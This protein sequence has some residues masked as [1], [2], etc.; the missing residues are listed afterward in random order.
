M[1]KRTEKIENPSFLMLPRAILSDKR[2][3][4][5]DKL[6]Y[7]QIYTLDRNNEKENAYI[8]NGRLSEIFGKSITTISR[9]ISKLVDNGYLGWYQNYGNRKLFVIIEALQADND[10]KVHIK[11]DNKDSKSAIPSYQKRSSD[12]SKMPRAHSKN[13]M[14][15]RIAE[16]NKIIKEKIEKED[17]IFNKV[18]QNTYIDELV[19]NESTFTSFTKKVV[20][21]LEERNYT[22]SS[23]HR[24]LEYISSMLHQS[25]SSRKKIATEVLL[26]YKNE[27]VF[28]ERINEL[29][30]KYKLPFTV[31]QF[32]ATA[33]KIK[34]DDVQQDLEKIILRFAY[35]N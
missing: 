19:T 8:S 15:N 28:L 11:N 6:V 21:L 23:A 2:I 29:L 1:K 20:A 18:F 14:Y 17:F 32:E 33:P 34:M 16:E 30:G 27:R 4:A 5:F 13:D 31:A 25:F 26:Y 3:S 12:L 10:K 22:K 35:R 9:S 7:A 24:A